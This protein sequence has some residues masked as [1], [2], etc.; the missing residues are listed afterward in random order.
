MGISEIGFPPWYR[1]R[2]RER[3]KERQEE[4]KI[5]KLNLMEFYAGVILKGHAPHLTC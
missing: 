4:R 1:E 5:H 2:R 3:E